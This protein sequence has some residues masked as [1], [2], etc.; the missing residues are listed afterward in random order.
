MHLA[1]QNRNVKPTPQQP[2]P[3][4]V[5]NPL[6]PANVRQKRVRNDAEALRN[7]DV[8]TALHPQLADYYKLTVK[9]RGGGWRQLKM[10][11]PMHRTN[12]K[13]AYKCK[14]TL[15]TLR[16]RPL[17]F[18]ILLRRTRYIPTYSTLQTLRLYIEAIFLDFS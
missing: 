16:E 3:L 9:N 5:N 14:E 18:S 4:L 8:S 17:N 7:H 12:H 6:N 2:L 15:A 1:R 11:S 10:Q 13:C